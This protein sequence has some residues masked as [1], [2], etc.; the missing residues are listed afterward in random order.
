MLGG[1]VPSPEIRVQRVDLVEVGEDA[2]EL[3]IHLELHNK[4]D[5]PV[6]LEIWDYSLSAAATR[7]AGRWSAGITIPP[8]ETMN[9]VIPAVLPN[10]ASPGPTTAWSASGSVTYL[11]PS[12]LAEA[13]FELGLNRPSQSFSGRGDGI[14]TGGQVPRAF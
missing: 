11:A 8:G 5:V 12:R 4:A 13:L 6:K 9:A 2:S 3:A 1:C 7:Y 14:G 10:A